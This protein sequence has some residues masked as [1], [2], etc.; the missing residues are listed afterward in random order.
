MFNV[1]RSFR[2]FPVFVFY[3]RRDAR[4]LNVR[5]VVRGCGKY[6]VR[7]SL[8]LIQWLGVSLETFLLFDPMVDMQQ[9]HLI[10]RLLDDFCLRK[11]NHK[12]LLFF[13]SIA[14]AFFLSSTIEKNLISSPKQ[15]ISSL[16][17]LGK[18]ARIISSKVTR[19]LSSLS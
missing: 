12:T 11:K 5:Y 8:E 15:S 19:L 17:E 18:I 3:V 10:G 16:L 14:V 1:R 4:E 7:I 2:R 13:L 6:L 9:D